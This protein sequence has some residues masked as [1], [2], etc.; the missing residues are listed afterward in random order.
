VKSPH[1]TLFVVS[2]YCIY[3]LYQ[4]GHADHRRRRSDGDGRRKNSTERKSEADDHPLSPASCRTR[5]FLFIIAYVVS[6]VEDD[7]DD[8][9]EEDRRVISS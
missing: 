1:N 3:H 9:D 8:D 4:K 7:D 6:L 2:S 5:F